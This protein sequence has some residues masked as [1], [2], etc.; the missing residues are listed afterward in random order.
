MVPPVI[1]ATDQQPGDP[2]F[3]FNHTSEFCVPLSEEFIEHCAEGALSIE[4]WGHRGPGP[5]LE[6][7][8]GW[9]VEQQ[10]LAK[11]RSLVDR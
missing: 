1:S 6:G 7:L 2:V 10:Q 5:K 4:V 3:E 11:A 9:H 8:P